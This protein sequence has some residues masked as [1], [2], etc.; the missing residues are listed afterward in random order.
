[1]AQIST[2]KRGN[3][4]EYSFE[5]ASVDG[6]RKRKSKGGF[7]TKKECLEAGTKAKAEYDSCGTVN[8]ETMMSV[9][10]WL[11]IWYK[12]CIDKRYKP[13]TKET[14]NSVIRQI[15][16]QFGNYRLASL[17][18]LAINKWFNEL[19][20]EGYATSTV[21]NVRRILN[22]ALNYAYQ[23]CVIKENPCSRVRIKTSDSEKF[24]NT[25]IVTPDLFEKILKKFDTK[26]T[27]YRIPFLIGWFTGMRGG[28][29]L[30]LTWD[31]IDFE[32][33]TIHVCKTQTWAFNQ[34]HIHYPKTPRSV[35]D[36]AVGDKL[37]NELKA[38]REVQI[39]NANKLDMEAPKFICTRN[40][41]TL[42]SVI[43][44][45]HQSM[46]V[47]R[48]LDIDFHFHCLRHTHATLLIKNGVS[49]KEVQARLGHTSIQTTLDIYTHIK[50]SESIKS[51]DVFENF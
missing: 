20:D 44:L 8:N 35:R 48:E 6:K 16:R 5:I 42:L 37:I 33:K 47:A 45:R 10:D 30:G 31:D 1:M 22:G 3:T 28:E 32:N 9:S 34:I 19:I 36:I 40:N 17:T 26:V 15:K 41:L 25:L 27:Y 12:D 43:N 29:V 11:D 2:R 39:D 18:P 46:S 14:Y 51:V 38:W 23:M 49:V 7:R 13:A 24:K 21:R 4:W 50:A